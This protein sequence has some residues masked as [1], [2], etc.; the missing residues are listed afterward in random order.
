MTNARPSRK[1]TSGVKWKDIDF[2]GLFLPAVEIFCEIMRYGVL[3]V[4]VKYLFL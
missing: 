4:S 1:K 3:N 2:S